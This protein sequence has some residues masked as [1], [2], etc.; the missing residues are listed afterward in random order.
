MGARARISVSAPQCCGV[1]S[2][3]KVGVFEQILD[4]PIT[5]KG[6]VEARHCVDLVGDL[7]LYFLDDFVLVA[8]LFNDAF[9]Q[10]QNDRA[11][12]GSRPS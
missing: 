8:V 10:D 2:H 6:L 12:D 5:S 3:L 9:S 1:S 4:S 7:D 11:L